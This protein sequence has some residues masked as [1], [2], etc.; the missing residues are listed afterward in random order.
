MIRNCQNKNMPITENQ[1]EELETVIKK[2]NC[3]IC[4][5]ESMRERCKEAL[6][7]TIRERII[8]DILNQ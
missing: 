2:I 7:S 6:E 1:R 8:R 3:M 5:K 4:K